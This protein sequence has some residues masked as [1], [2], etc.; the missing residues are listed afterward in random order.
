MKFGKIV[1]EIGAARVSRLG[2]S[3]FKYLII[4]RIIGK[5]L[6]YFICK[7]RTETMSANRLASRGGTAFPT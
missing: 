4:N 6:I 2:E 3:V 5:I 7:N 1:R